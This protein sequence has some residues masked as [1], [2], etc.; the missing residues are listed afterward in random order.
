MLSRK[1]SALYTLLC[2]LLLSSIL[3][4]PLGSYAKGEMNNEYIY[5]GFVP[6]KIYI[7]RPEKIVGGEILG[8]E[9]YLDE[10]SVRTEAE[11][12][13][14]GNHNETNVKIFLFPG[15]S[16]KEDFWVNRLEK[17]VFK[18]QN[19]SFFKIVSSKP[20]TVVLAGGE[21]VEVGNDAVSTFWTSTDGGFI[22][23]EFIFQA[24]QGKVG[25]SYYLYALEDC[26]VKLLS[27]NGVE[28]AKYSLKAG[29][30]KNLL[31]VTQFKTYRIASTGMV[32]LQSFSGSRS[33]FF[34]SLEGGFVGKT[35]VGRAEAKPGEVWQ[36]WQFL[37]V[38][39][40]K[41][42]KVK[43][44]DLE[45]KRP[46]DEFEVPSGNNYSLKIKPSLIF[47]ESDNPITVMHLSYGHPF[48]SNYIGG[49]LVCLV[50]K[51]GQTAPLYVPEESEAYL[52]VAEETII[53]LDGARLRLEEDELIQLQPGFH[54]LSSNKN[55][56]LMM[57]HRPL[58]PPN[59]GLYSFGICIPPIQ[60]A[61]LEYSVKLNLT[62]SP[63]IPWM[64]II[65]GAL[66]TSILAAFL[67][68]ALRKRRRL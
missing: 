7:Y 1:N 47:V 26:E 62:S 48:K 20:V 34:P 13:I 23:K 33:V 66:G 32:M 3:P 45:Y 37:V 50:I 39:P 5:F 51:A 31:E 65:V 25:S 6:S 58:L 61:N 41:D 56:L 52:F 53:D 46:Y 44:M 10:R 59:Q 30:V 15:P 22:G 18:I 2:F 11:L 29:D 8:R 55:S 57:A 27:E 35:F 38:N 21:G 67:W 54:L 14:L 17:R 36:E 40:L 60:S 19:G 63:E 16:L 24:I 42:T 68:L 43:I 4:S 28:A 64:L 49:G 12:T 9:F